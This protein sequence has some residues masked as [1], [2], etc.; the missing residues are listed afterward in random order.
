MRLKNAAEESRTADETVERAV[1]ATMTRA[2]A[3]RGMLSALLGITQGDAATK[4]LYT[5][6]LALGENGA[7]Y[8]SRHRKELC[9]PVATKLSHI[10]RAGAEAVDQYERGIVAGRVA[11]LAEENTDARNGSP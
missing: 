2:K 1:S 9:V 4:P 11:A 3:R 5:T 8:I 7:S 6:L 10:S